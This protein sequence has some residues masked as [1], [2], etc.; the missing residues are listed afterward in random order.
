MCSSKVAWTGEQR[1][2]PLQRLDDIVYAQQLGSNQRL[3]AYGQLTVGV[4]YRTFSS[5]GGT[6]TVIRNKAHTL[7]MR[8]A[9]CRNRVDSVLW[10]RRYH[11][12]H[13]DGRTIRLG[14]EDEVWWWHARVGETPGAWSARVL[15]DAASYTMD[16]NSNGRYRGCF[17][18]K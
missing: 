1:F 6:K 2:C 10:I 9:S 11:R 5:Y 13:V 8:W 14:S 7:A 12:N 18:V 17:A 16:G 15:S 3:V 4:Q